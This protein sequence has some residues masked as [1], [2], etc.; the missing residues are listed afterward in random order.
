MLYREHDDARGG[1][2]SRFTTLPPVHLRVEGLEEVVGPDPTT[3]KSAVGWKGGADGVE[4]GS[5]LLLVFL[6]GSTYLRRFSGVFSV[7]AN[8][9]TFGVYGI[10]EGYSSNF[11]I[12]TGDWRNVGVDP[13]P[14]STGSILRRFLRCSRFDLS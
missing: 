8:A 6:S 4:H 1:R 7:Y 10:P 13:F 3:E 11:D 14:V 2:R 12:E 5:P 9:M